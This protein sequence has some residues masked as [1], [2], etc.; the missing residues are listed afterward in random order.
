ML[1]TCPQRGGVGHLAEFWSWH[2]WL[3][4]QPCGLLP[5]PA[6]KLR[7]WDEAVGG[8]GGGLPC[9]RFWMGLVEYKGGSPWKILKICPVGGV[10]QAVLVVYRGWTSPPQAWQGWGGGSRLSTHVVGSKG[11]GGSRV[12]CRCLVTGSLRLYLLNHNSV[13]HDHLAGQGV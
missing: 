12:A 11:R 2:T 1:Q 9:T 13:G 10:K 6:G 7:T 5:I 8:M 4:T 3:Y